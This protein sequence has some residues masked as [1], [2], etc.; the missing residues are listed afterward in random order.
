MMSF[1]REISKEYDDNLSELDFPSISV[2]PTSVSEEDIKEYYLTRK[3]KEAKQRKLAYISQFLTDDIGYTIKDV[4]KMLDENQKV[5]RVSEEV[6]Q[7]SHLL[8][9]KM[10]AIMARLVQNTDFKDIPEEDDEDEEPKNK[11]DKSNK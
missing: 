10:D 4:E 6:E 1:I 3:E 11:T 5:H 2:A 8:D 7:T 9:K